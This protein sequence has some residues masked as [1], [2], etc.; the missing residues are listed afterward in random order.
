LL[1]VSA[2]LTS[3]LTRVDAK[4]NGKLILHGSKDFPITSTKP[5]T[6]GV[7]FKATKVTVQGNCCWKMYEHIKTARGPH[8]YLKKR[9]KFPVTLSRKNI[10]SVF[11]EPCPIKRSST[12]LVAVLATVGIVAVLS[13][14]IILVFRKCRNRHTQ[15]PTEDPEKKEEKKVKEEKEVKELE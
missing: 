3:S 4:C 13:L 15:L 6:F 9:G 8:Q 7:N 12:V 14:L 10:G 1:S 11:K 5:K 2:I